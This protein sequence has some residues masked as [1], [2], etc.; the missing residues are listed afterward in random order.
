MKR[1]AAS[2]LLLLVAASVRAAP[3]T[4]ASIQRGHEFAEGVA[5][6][7]ERGV[8]WLKK[9]QSADG[10]YPQIP[11]C[12]GATAAFAYHALRV[13]GTPREDFAARQTWSAMQSSAPRHEP[14]TYVA[15]VCLMAL[16]EHGKRDPAA[17][18]DRDTTL[19]A[20]DAKWA[21]ELVAGLVKTRMK[22]SGWTYKAPVHDDEEDHSNTQ[23]ALLGLKAAARCG[24]AVEPSVWIGALRHL[25]DVQARRGAA[26]PRKGPG[27]FIDRLRAWDYRD[28]SDRKEGGTVAM[29]AGCV[30]SLVICR[31]EAL[32]TPAMSAELA[33]TSERAIRD[34]L[35]WV[36]AH[37]APSA[38]PGEGD[39]YAA[40][41]VERAGVLA[42][43]DWM[44]ELDWYGRGA[45]ALLA[46][47]SPDGSWD[48]PVTGLYVDLKKDK[49]SGRARRLV[50][51]CF[52]LLF[53]K[54]GTTPVH[55]GAVTD[56]DAFDINFAAAARTTGRDFED[57]V[58]RRWRQLDDP[59][60]RR[61]LFDCATATGPRIVEPALVRLAA[62]DQSVRRAA[63]A[64]LRHA[65]GLDFGF[66]ADAGPREEA[67]DKWRAWFLETKAGLVYDP[68]TKRI[69][70]PAPN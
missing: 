70:V 51:T 2:L 16:A 27:F 36:G 19:D 46:T 8:A 63:D 34:G 1:A 56:Q 23:Y 61:R 64:F 35:A 14:S 38:A 57:F 41:A 25:C 15:A 55:R 68:L 50:N 26:V 9:A 28:R 59:D 58:L 33:R 11:A 22:S 48:S 52:A 69:A 6:A 67:A 10:S 44:G 30:G 53:L 18:D 37:W 45:D 62:D 24:I 21:E 29:T 43:V 54:R 40:Y 39:L 5:R 12:P 7:V 42:A 66:I 20:E 47:Q 13:C 4:P 65:T 3:E 31:S 32:G 17:A 60:D 49:A